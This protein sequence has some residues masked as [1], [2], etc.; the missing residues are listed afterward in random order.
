MVG[1]RVIHL[2]HGGLRF[3]NFAQ[4]Q[5]AGDTRPP[6]RRR[7]GSIQ[8][9]LI[10]GFA[11][12]TS[13]T[14]LA[15]SAAFI[16]YRSLA[17]EFYQIEND[18]LPPLL[19]LI[20]ITRQIAA[21]SGYLTNIARAETGGELEN[22]MS[23]ITG[24]RSAI[25]ANLEAIPAGRERM[26]QLKSL[27]SLIEALC[28][29][30]VLLGNTTS[31][32]ITLRFERLS[33]MGDALKAHKKIFAMLAPLVDDANFNLTMKLRQQA[34]ETSRQA[35]ETE[36]AGLGEKELPALVALSD[37]RSETN[38]II[39]ILGEASLAAEQVQF[40]PLRDRLQAS[41][42]RARTALKELAG[43]PRIGEIAPLVKDLLSYADDSPVI[44]VRDRELSA[45]NR[46][47]K[48]VHEGRKLEGELA[49]AVEGAASQSREA[50][51]QL[52]ADSNKEIL[53][54][55]IFLALL[56][57]SGVAALAS[58]YTFIRRHI[59]ERLSG[60]RRAI[61]K[62]A[63]GD[64][65]VAVPS[66]GNDELADMGTAVETFKANALKLRELEAERT[67]NF[68]RANAALKAKSEF[69]SNMS[70][71]LRTPMHAILSYAKL[72]I[73]ATKE[74][75]VPELETYYSN[76]GKAGAR[77]LSLINNLLDLAKL[78]S[79]KMPFS[80][81][82]G[83][84]AG[85]LEQALL[86]MAPLLNEKSLTVS[87]KI[88]TANTKLIFDKQR[89]IQV[90][91]NLLANS[92]K[93]SPKGASIDVSVLDGK[94][95]NGEA[96]LCCSIADNGTGIPESE[97]EMVFDK[98]MQSSKT[99]TGAGGTG[100]GLAICREIVEAHGGRIWAENRQPKGA[101]FNFTIAKNSCQQAS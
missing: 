84:F 25:I 26:R 89:M 16:T 41:T 70:H 98:F 74:K 52:V 32:R 23:A 69:L 88:S 51:S 27:R 57:V 96:A 33:L 14:F 2:L 62:V 64:L 80:K 43:Y 54:G 50:V 67:K 91:I 31:E 29:N 45:D 24:L 19:G 77:L 99:K 92:A 94:L 66:G 10:F 7:R 78:E 9:K 18:R 55:S 35:H 37:L 39:G 5:S 95:P 48:L 76:I 73:E 93:F 11:I 21:L 46:G 71:E 68:E 85:V 12:V 17:G 83:D 56:S 82:A 61:V 42:A 79:G 38:L 58:A 40:V 20:G 30:G 6:Q 49:T 22:A 28:F 8:S 75:K 59:T 3:G 4:A 60:L 63:G 87:T 15:T 100:L 47:W 72:G 13:F 81:A 97:L 34:S 90:M 44:R 1:A 101:R 53:I 86:E 36:V 65:E